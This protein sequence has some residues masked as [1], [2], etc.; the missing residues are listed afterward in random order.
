MFFSK[1]ENVSFFF[2]LFLFFC[3]SFSS[4]FFMYVYIYIYIYISICFLLFFNLGTS[5]SSS[6]SRY[7]IKSDLYQPKN[8][9]HSF[10]VIGIILN[11]LKKGSTLVDHVIRSMICQK[12]VK[13]TIVN[14]LIDRKM[15]AT[16]S[17]N[18]LKV[19]KSDH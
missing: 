17:L 11:K 7:R 8:Y 9:F 4:F 16:D 15:T 10:R 19:I 6:N 3:P 2:I 1:L 14:C 5:I 12:L 13:I 18:L